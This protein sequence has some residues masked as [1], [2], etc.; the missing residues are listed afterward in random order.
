MKVSKFEV[1]KYH[2]TPPPFP[3]NLLT[4]PIYYKSTNNKYIEFES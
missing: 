3:K 4:I 2:F 1:D